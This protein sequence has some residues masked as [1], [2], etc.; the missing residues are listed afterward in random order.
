[1]TTQRRLELEAAAFRIMTGII[2]PF[3]DNAPATWMD[4]H[5]RQQR[6]EEWREHYSLIISAME[7][8]FDELAFYDNLPKDDLD[9]PDSEE[10]PGA[11]AV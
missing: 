2:V 10:M 3:K 11:D 1:M 5:D 9:K 7:K 8:A 4:C 6:W